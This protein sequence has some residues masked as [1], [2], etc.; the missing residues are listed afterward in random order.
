MIKKILITL[1]I[2]AATLVPSLV[3]S[4][5]AFAVD[6]LGNSGSACHNSDATTTPSLCKDNRTNGN[7]PIYGKTGILTAA[8][9]ILAKVVGVV[10]IV[11]IVVSGVRMIISQDASA[12]ANARRGIMSAAVGLAIALLAQ[13]LVSFVL[14]KL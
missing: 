1:T 2:F 10:S 7:N 8:I 6:V 4:Q 12:S 11:I 13:A 5:P 14:S 3:A 9:N